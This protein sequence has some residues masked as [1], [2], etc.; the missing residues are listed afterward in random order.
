MKKADT[1]Y[2]VSVV[3]PTYKRPELLARCLTAL[4]EQ[5]LDPTSYEI[6]I[7]DDAACE[8]TRHEIEGWAAR[9]APCGHT[10][11]YMP[12]TGM[13]GPAIARNVG[14]RAAS[15]KI[16]AFTD[17]DCLPTAG[18]LRAG[19]AAFT[20]GV[21]G[22]SGRLVMP[23]REMPTDYELNAAQLVHAEF[24]TA[25]CFYRRECL[26]AISGFDER[27]TAAWRE[28]S[29]LMFRLTKQ[30]KRSIE[31][32]VF[33]P[34]AVVVHPIRPAQWGVSLKQQRKSMFN[35]LLYKKHPELYRQ[36]VQSTPPWHY[37]GI[38]GCILTFMFGLLTGKHLIAFGAASLWMVLTGRFLLRRLSRTSRQRRH[39]AEMLVTSLLIPPL[40]IYWRLRGAIKFRVFFL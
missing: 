38:S 9:I 11:R 12:V 5:D 4:V 34:H 6:I 21:V 37:Y 28:D 17:D 20:E 16:I 30:Y 26:K 22:V 13:H 14:W 19:L 15:G 23:L 31:S 36:K 24:I 10:L 2:C 1:T 35:A 8:E 29:D 32:F 25:N 39:V 33:A 3:V 18:W 7:V 27:F 40:A